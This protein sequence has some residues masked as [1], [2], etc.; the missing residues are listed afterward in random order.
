MRKSRGGAALLALAAVGSVVAAC[1]AGN[2]AGDAGEGGVADAA[3]AGVALSPGKVDLLLAIDTSNAGIEAQAS[4]LAQFE[5]VLRSLVEPPRG[6][7]GQ[8]AHRAVT[9]LRVGV[10]STDLGVGANT[11]PGCAAPDG[12]DGRLNPLRYGPATQQHLPWM[13]RQGM[14]A[15]PGFR[16]DDC[17][18]PSEFPAFV[19][20]CSEGAGVTCGDASRD[21]VRFVRSVRCTAGLYG[22]GCSVAQPLEAI[23]RALRWHDARAGAASSSPNAGFV[24]DDALLAIVLLAA[25]DDFSVRDCRFARGAPCA[26]A[27]DALRPDATAWASSSLA[28]RGALARPCTEQDP[29]WPLE[30][31]LDPAAPDAGLLA[32]KPGHPERIV[33]AAL[34][35]V[36]LTLPTRSEGGEAR[37]DWGS[38]LGTPSVRGA[39]DYC[40]R[41]GAAA[42]SAMSREGPVTMRP[43]VLDPSC[44][45]RVLPACHREGTEY[46]A[47]CGAGVPFAAPPARRIAELARRFDESPVCAGGPC[48][49]GSVHSICGSNVSAV[50]DRLRA[51]LRAAPAR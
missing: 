8:P 32:L 48:R 17:N 6:A 15:P 28:L 41:E 14:A 20:F 9:D 39:E 31:Y 2:P 22:N 33:F 24:R 42:V 12:D 16:P 13:P 10:I 23:W 35:G 27:T 19:G 46:V 1:T 43:G 25:S 11:V 18:D 47:G 37:T 26:D 5:P 34:T 38:L 7:D 3:D 44:A 4:L 45:E 50:F 29:T 49:N 51:R 36:P 30:R 21:P 40:G